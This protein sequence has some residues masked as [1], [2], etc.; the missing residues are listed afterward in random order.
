MRRR[1]NMIAAHFAPSD[2]ISISTTHVLPMVINLFCSFISA[3][4]LLHICIYEKYYLVWIIFLWKR[5]GFAI[6]KQNTDY[7]CLLCQLQ[8]ITVKFL[9]SRF[10]IYLFK[11]NSISIDAFFTGYKKNF[12]FLLP[13]NF[14]F[15]NLLFKLKFLTTD[16]VCSPSVKRTR[17]K[18][19]L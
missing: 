4:L 18:S 17:N 1:I 16:L 5:S 15:L 7:A 19:V 11:F 8:L 9:G 10:E 2:E 3:T 12:R 14:H 13:K 6:S